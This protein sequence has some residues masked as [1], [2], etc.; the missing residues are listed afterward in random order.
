MPSM[1]SMEAMQ[2]G[3][4]RIVLS[5]LAADTCGRAMLG[6]HSV[7]LAGSVGDPSPTG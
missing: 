6:L 1:D 3:V 5:V 2:C 4:Q 7:E